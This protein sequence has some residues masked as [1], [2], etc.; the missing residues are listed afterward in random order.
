MRNFDIFLQYP[1]AL[2][3]AQA[4][5]EYITL[6]LNTTLNQSFILRYEENVETDKTIACSFSMKLLPKLQ[7]FQSDMYGKCRTCETG[8]LTEQTFLIKAVA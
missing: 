5:L 1:V 3:K 2:T 8:E 6:C 7:P 4:R